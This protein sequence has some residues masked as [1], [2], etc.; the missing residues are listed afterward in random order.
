M[1]VCVCVCVCVGGCVRERLTPPVVYVCVFLGTN[2]K[3]PLWTL[4]GQCLCAS[5]L[6]SALLC[7]AWVEHR[8]AVE[9]LTKRGRS[10]RSALFRVA[11]VTWLGKAVGEEGPSW[12][13]VSVVGGVW[14]R[15]SVVGGV[16]PLQPHVPRGSQ[17]ETV[18]S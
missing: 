5:P 12:F 3:S 10:I 2:D 4:P 7:S 6:R 18:P 16:W 8:K 15:V 9:F 17:T 13:R 1:C 14:F 11:G